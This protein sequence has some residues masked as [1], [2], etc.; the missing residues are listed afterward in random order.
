MASFSTMDKFGYTCTFGS[1]KVNIGYED[2]VIRQCYLFL[3]DN[4]LNLL[5]VITP[6]NLILHTSTRGSDNMHL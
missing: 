1:K 6:S 5:N 2:N 4:N 3:Q